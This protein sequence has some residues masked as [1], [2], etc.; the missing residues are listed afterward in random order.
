MM[1][2]IPIG[3]KEGGGGWIQ[4]LF[5]NL[6]FIEEKNNQW[7]TFLNWTAISNTIKVCAKLT[8]YWQ[9]NSDSKSSVIF[10]IQSLSPLDMGCGT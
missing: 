1:N 8:S 6:T 10:L 4:N 2:S 7:V 9:F 3:V 5:F